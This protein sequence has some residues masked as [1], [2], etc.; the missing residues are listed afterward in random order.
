VP[1]VNFRIIAKTKSK[2]NLGWRERDILFTI[3]DAANAVSDSAEGSMRSL[4]GRGPDA[5]LPKSEHTGLAMELRDV[6]YFGPK[7]RPIFSE[8]DYD[9]AKRLLSEHAQTLKPFLEAGRFQSLIRELSDYEHRSGGTPA[10]SAG[11]AANSEVAGRQRRPQRRW[12][13]A[14]HW[15]SG[16][17]PA[18]V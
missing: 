16:Q 10:A 11:Q 14:G 3:L 13:D 7:A 4:A 5:Y 1:S 15:G 18:Y 8:R 12:S 2:P 17:H 6:T 9:A